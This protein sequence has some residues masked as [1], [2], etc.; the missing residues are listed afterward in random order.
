VR[1]MWR[2]IVLM[3]FGICYSLVRHGRLR[4]GIFW[5]VLGFAEFAVAVRPLESSVGRRSPESV[6][7]ARESAYGKP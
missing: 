3:P 2:R 5:D 6:G 7:A 4:A 1:R